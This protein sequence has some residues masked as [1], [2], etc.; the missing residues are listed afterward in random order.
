MVL[1][2]CTVY[3][4]YTGTVVLY[5][6]Y[7]SFGLFSFS[8]VGPAAVCEQ[9]A[10][11][12]L[13]DTLTAMSEHKKKKSKKDKKE[14][15]EKKRSRDETTSQA[16]AP[17]ASKKARVDAAPATVVATTLS[18][19]ANPLA[20]EKLSK[21]LL[22][23][24]KRSAKVKNALKR[25]V[26]EVTKAVRKEQKGL[27]VIAGDISPID[28]ITFLPMLCEEKKLT[29]CYVRSKAELGAAA[30]TKRPT[31]CVMI[32][33]ASGFEHQSS[34]DEL[35]AQVAAIFPKFD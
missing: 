29:Y 7:R 15:K 10:R 17:S 32:T 1:W 16:A 12:F 14:K 18:P 33:P 34:F 13:W 35:S 31:S 6:I 19:I 30:Q 5:R 28:V 23:L 21:K 9:C 20:G 3:T 26:K 2:Y 8:L 24:V 11:S 4:V 22:K 27:V 25:G